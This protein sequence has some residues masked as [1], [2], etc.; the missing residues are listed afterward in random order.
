MSY[1]VLARKYRP[2]AFEEMTGQEHVV[3]TVE[4]A[5]KLDRVAHAYLFCGPRGVGKTTVAAR[6][7]SELARRGLA[8]GAR[9]LANGPGKLCAALGLDGACYGEDLT[10][11]RLWLAE[12]AR[13]AVGV[14]PRI[15]IDYAGEWANKAW[16]FYERANRHVSV[17]PRD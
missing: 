3:R 15:N 4:N 10:G 16:R 6:V 12:G 7:A 1:T 2:Q 11:E 8:V 9:T 13:G 14:S 5:I 17:A